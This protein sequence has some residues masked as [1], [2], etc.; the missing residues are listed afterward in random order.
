LRE[1]EKYDAAP[2][3]SPKGGGGRTGTAQRNLKTIF[4]HN[5]TYEEKMRSLTKKGV[6][7]KAVGGIAKH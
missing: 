4:V 5:Q 3:V 6:A 1:T 2:A 7:G